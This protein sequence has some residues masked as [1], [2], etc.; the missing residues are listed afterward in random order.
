MI[1]TF[2]FF[3][4]ETTGLITKA[5]MPRITEMSL[6]GVT[7]SAICD[8]LDPL[9]RVLHKLVIPV[10]P[11]IQISKK[12]TEITGNVIFYCIICSILFHFIS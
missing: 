6:I 1:R 8:T 4:L 3:D 7:R 9:P 2:I 5:S 10:H 12:I 11:G